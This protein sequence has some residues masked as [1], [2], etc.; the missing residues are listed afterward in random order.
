MV[1]TVVST[2]RCGPGQ[3]RHR[4]GSVPT[5]PSVDPKPLQHPEPAPKL[6]LARR[7]VVLVAVLAVAAL[8]LAVQP[9][10]SWLI[11]QFAGADAIIRQHGTWSMA[12]F[13]ALAALSAMIAFVSSSVL[14][15]VA[16]HA[17]GPWA[18]A[19]LLWAGWFLGGLAAYAI[20]RFWPASGR[21]SDEARGC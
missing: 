12:L 2:R 5:S 8:I 17:W 14:I 19:A 11:G 7:A 18:C 13:V 16:V 1:M 10:H 15:P 6:W 3:H 20:G 9:L 4:L 21:P